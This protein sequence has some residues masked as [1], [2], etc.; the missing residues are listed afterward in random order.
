MRPMVPWRTLKRINELRRQ[1]P[2]VTKEALRQ[3]LA[4]AEEHGIPGD[5]NPKHM[6]KAAKQD[7]AQWDAY[8]PLLVTKQLVGVSGQCIPMMFVNLLT[9]LRACYK[10]G[11]IFP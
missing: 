6:R 1:V 3:V 10:Q 5:H 9:L 7:L 2:H 4:H 11:R 8:G